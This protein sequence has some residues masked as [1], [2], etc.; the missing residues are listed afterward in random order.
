[1]TPFSASHGQE[2]V[3]VVGIILLLIGYLAPLP[4]P[5]DQIAIVIVWILVVVGA[6]LMLLAADV[7]GTDLDRPAK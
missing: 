1:M 4:M 2:R 5:L 3:I 7:T 6:I